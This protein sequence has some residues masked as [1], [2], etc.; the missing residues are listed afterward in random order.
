MKEV[1]SNLSNQTSTYSSSVRMVIDKLGNGSFV[2]KEELAHLLT[3]I[4]FEDTLY[5]FEKANEVKTRFYQNRVFLRALI[6]ISNYCTREC[7][8]CGISGLIKRG[9]R[10]R[11]DKDT[12]MQSIDQAARKGYQTFVIQGGED[13]YFQVDLLVEYIKDIKK[14]YPD[15]RITLSLGEKSYDDYKKLF[16]AGADRYLLRHETASKALYNEI[17]G[18]SMSFEKRRS[19]LRDLKNIGFQVGAGFMVGLP[20]QSADDLASDLVFLRELNPEMVGI[21]PFIVHNETLMKDATSGGYLETTIMVALARLVLPKALIPATTALGVLDP[22]GREK[23][24][25]RGA[26]V[27][28]PNVSPK[29]NLQK[30]EI[31]KNKTYAKDQTLDDLEVRLNDMGLLLDFSQGDVYGWRQEND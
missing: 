11:M 7:F 20:N 22:Q 5:L 12:L 10:Y 3:H 30:Y 13:P 15:K 1:F 23:A 28:M 24:L 26:N 6:E 4:A 21:G 8:Y 27:L 29:D 18:A 14:A 25:L 31:Y 16:D 19:C 2:G 17:H 9:D